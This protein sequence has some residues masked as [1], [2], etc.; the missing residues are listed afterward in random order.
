MIFTPKE[1]FGNLLICK[2][3]QKT[4]KFFRNMLLMNIFIDY[5][6]ETFY[7]ISISC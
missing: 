2:M 1:I 6:A 3:K 4:S 5:T 7:T